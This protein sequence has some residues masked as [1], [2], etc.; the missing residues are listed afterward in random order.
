[1]PTQPGTPYEQPTITDQPTT[2][3]EQPTVTEPTIEI[4]E[5]EYETLEEPYVPGGNDRETPPRPNTPGNELIPG[6][7]GEWIEVDEN[8]VPQYVWT[9][10]EDEEEWVSEPIPPKIN[11]TFPDDEPTLPVIPA[12]PLVQPKKDNPTT[13]DTNAVIFSLLGI[14]LI[15]GCVTTYV[16]GK[17]KRSVK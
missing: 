5:E 6:E 8:G 12:K 7:N 2:P 3:E 13:G 1:M 11:I 10:D 4:T 16:V 9:W 15:S 14:L 17:K